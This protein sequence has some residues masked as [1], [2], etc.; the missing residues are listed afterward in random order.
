MDAK[1]S[2]LTY[3]LIVAMRVASFRRRWDMPLLYGPRYFY[4]VHVGEGFYEG[5]GRKLLHLYRAL[6]LWPFLA[7]LAIFAVLMFRRN[8]SALTGLC[9]AALLAMILNQRL[10][11][12]ILSRT[13]KKFEEKELDPAPAA[14]S[15]SLNPRRL[16][17]YST[18][19]FEITLASVITLTLVFL[20]QMRAP[21]GPPLV[22]LYL[23]IGFLLIKKAI[24][25]WRAAA[26]L[27]NSEIYLEVRERR[28]RLLLFACDFYRGAAGFVMIK[29]AVFQ[30]TTDERARWTLQFLYLAVTIACVCF[31]VIK[32]NELYAMYRKLKPLRDKKRLSAPDP[33]GFVA[34]GLLYFDR[35]NPAIFVQG[36]RS[37]TLN[38]AN[39]RLL[40]AATYLLGLMLLIMWN[41]KTQRAS[42]QEGLPP[43]GAPATMISAHQGSELPKMRP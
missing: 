3:F 2:L 15:F 37:V 30:V 12:A 11:M 43:V 33:N 39:N 10:V 20:A 7:E 35:D 21:M 28:R 25:D 27:E 17:D 13:A 1:F 5:G 24:V 18:P 8:Y 22:L 40:L 31:A 19:I 41:N 26:P 6:L 34:G 9:V 38:A 14:I 36:P 4:R 16:A 23:Q 29:E 42:S 32:T